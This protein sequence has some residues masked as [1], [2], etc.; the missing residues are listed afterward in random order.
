MKRLLIL[1]FCLLLPVAALAD[2][3]YDRQTRLWERVDE[4]LRLNTGYAPGAYQH[5]QIIGDPDNGW[6]FSIKLLEHPQDEDGVICYNI[7]P[8]G[9]LI[10]EQGPNKISLGMQAMYAIYDCSGDDCYL[11][12]AQLIQDW[13][14]RL[15]ELRDTDSS[16][17][18]FMELDIRFPEEGMISYEEALA[19][20]Q[21]VLLS[22]PGWSEETLSYYYL[23]YCAYMQPGDLDKP[24]WLFYYNLYIPSI[25]EVKDYEELDRLRDE[26]YA[27]TINGAPAPV[28]FCVLIDAA[29]GSL[30][31]EPRYD[32]VPIQYGFWDYFERPVKFFH[33]DDGENG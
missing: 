16:M 18:R 1:C 33:T 23:K 22:Q 8:D 31:E 26:A 7:T 17:A 10:Y 28:Q 32:Y 29:D 5:G 4:L 6:S 24:V 20:V 19:A 25:D 15:D 3:A 13:K 12:V 14:P 9:T 21:S 30:V 2:T 27:H 11:R